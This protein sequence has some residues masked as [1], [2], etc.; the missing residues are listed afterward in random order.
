MGPSAASLAISAL[1]WA[2]TAGVCALIVRAL[3]RAGGRK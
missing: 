3:W 2:V 1:A